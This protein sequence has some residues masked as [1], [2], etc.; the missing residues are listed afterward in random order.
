MDLLLEKGGKA[1]I[2]ADH[3]NAEMM[4]D[5]RDNSPITSHTTNKV[6]LI[7]V[8]EENIK[9]REGILADIAPTILDMMG[10]EKPKEMTGETLII[11][12]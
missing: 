1:I 8:G 10:I 9:L 2:T 4:K 7:L 3:G 11:A 12:N 5:E 6:P